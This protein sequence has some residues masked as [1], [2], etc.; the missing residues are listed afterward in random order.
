MYGGNFYEQCQYIYMTKQHFIP[1]P[2]SI[3]ED[4]WNSLSA[5]D[6]EIVQRAF[7]D[8][9]TYQFE[10][11]EEYLATATEKIEESGCEIIDV[12]TEEWAEAT[13]SV[14]DD[15]VGTNG[16]EQEMVDKIKASAEELSAE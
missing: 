3:N 13:A 9:R 7:D 11:A 6:Q 5:E 4:L 10:A 15:W 8:S 1:A 2:V 16:I 12:D 14:Y